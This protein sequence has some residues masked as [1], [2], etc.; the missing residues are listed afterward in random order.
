MVF[1]HWLFFIAGLLEFSDSGGVDYGNIYV[2]GTEEM[3]T[4][5]R[6]DLNAAVGKSLEDQEIAES[7][8]SL[9]TEE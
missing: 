3:N 2:R 7:S 4:G 5:K 8:I 9:Y 6:E 1:A